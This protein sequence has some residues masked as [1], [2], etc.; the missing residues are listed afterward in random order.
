MPTW[1]TSSL[2][3]AVEVRSRTR[4]APGRGRGRAPWSSSSPPSPLG[5]ATGDRRHN[6]QARARLL[7]RQDARYVDTTMNVVHVDDLADATCS[8]RGRGP[9]PQLHHR[10]GESVDVEAPRDALG[11]HGPAGARPQ[12]PLLARRRCS[13]WP[14]SHPRAHPR[15]RALGTLEAARMSRTHMLYRRQ[16]GPRRARLQ[17]AP[18]IEAVEGSARWF[19]PTATSAPLG[20]T[21]SPGPHPRPRPDQTSTTTLPVLPR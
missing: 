17:L 20:A 5:P 18:A 1:P 15:P 19:V 6:R 12:V 2:V 8:P 21:A 10:R 7:E 13:L 3:Q 16:P 9:G 14:R 11:G 4:G